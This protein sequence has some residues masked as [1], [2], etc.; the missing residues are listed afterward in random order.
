M[1]AVDTNLE[2]FPSDFNKAW[3]NTIA[4][5]KNIIGRI[6][7]KKFKHAA[8]AS[9]ETLCFTATIYLDGREVGDV[10]SDGNGGEACLYF[11]DWN[12][13]RNLADEIRQARQQFDGETVSISLH[14]LISHIA[15]KMVEDKQ[16]AAFTKKCH[17]KG[18]TVILCDSGLMT[19]CHPTAF[20]KTMN[21]LAAKGEKV[22]KI[23][24]SK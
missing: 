10:H 17:K 15:G 20:A 2:P 24:A 4:S 5:C 18:F 8:F 1:Q 21:E 7:L 14:D 12:V 22:T 6:T 3:N 11:A 23:V 9:R 19:G 16:I 13:E